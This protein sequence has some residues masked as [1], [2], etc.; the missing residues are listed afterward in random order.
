MNV[1]LD[2]LNNGV[3][4]PNLN[5]TSIV[6]IIKV[7]NPEKMSEFRPISLCNVIYKVIS[8]VLA[9]RLKQVLLDI[10]SPTQSAFVPRRLISNNVIVAYEVLHSMHAR[11]KGKTGALALKLDVGKAYDRVEWLFLQGIMQKLGFLEKWIE[12]VITCVTTTSF[13][14]LLNGKPYG[15]VT[16][17]RGICQ[18]EPLSPYLFLLCVKGFTSLLA[19][20]KSEGKIHGAS[21][22]RGAPKVSNLLFAN[23]FLL[24][25]RATQ[26]EVEV[27][28]EML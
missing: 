13:L 7:K 11:K 2:F 17:S 3:M 6:L 23:N 4:L 1:V 8:K 14:I 21:I 25:Y 16:P 15:N 19:K 28:S 5:H 18:G 27:V 10:I 24:F 26:N 20:A 9:N 22:C 12:R